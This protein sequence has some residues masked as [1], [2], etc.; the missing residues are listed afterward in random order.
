VSEAHLATAW[1]ADT[2]ARRVEVRRR[3]DPDGVFSANASY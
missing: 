3:Y 2:F 1:P